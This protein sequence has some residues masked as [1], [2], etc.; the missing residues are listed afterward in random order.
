MIIIPKQNPIIEN[1]NSYYL[2]I[3]KLLEH[4]QGTSGSGAIQFISASSEGVIFFDKDGILN[5]IFRN[6]NGEIEESIP[7]DRIIETA[8]TNNFVVNVYKID[9]EKINFLAN[10][11]GAEE[12][13]KDLSTDFTDL[14]GLIKKMNSENLTGY[15]H[16]AIN[17]D[18]ENGLIFFNA[19]EILG[20]SY[21]WEKGDLNRSREGMEVLKQK[22][23]ESGGNF[24]V[25]K[26]PL[27]KKEPVA[28]LKEISKKAPPN[29][30]NMLEELM[31]IFEG[32]ITANKR[33]KAGF[34]TLLRK[35]FIEKV[36][37]YHFLDPFAGE[38]QYSDHKIFFN[39]DAK[40]EQL[41][42][43]ITESIKEL[44]KELGILDQLIEELAP[45]TEQYSDRIRKF[46]IDL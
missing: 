2:D 11:S 23:K 26:I 32:V 13:Y 19:G 46:G 7:I 16:V 34:N 45:W 20:G 35:K 40:D 14:E 37:K 12:I 5:N 27:K 25:R 6:R 28:E 10:L 22:L 41:A 30:L 33:I 4:Y 3:R 43:G 42:K 15:I 8:A 17:K 9:H 31:V 36:D 18:K 44:A 29:I 38:F 39:G 21:S 1:L 24:S